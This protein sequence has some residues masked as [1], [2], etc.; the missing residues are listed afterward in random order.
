[1]RSPG[2]CRTSSRT[3]GSID[4]DP[5]V[6]KIRV[7]TARI[8]VRA[9]LVRRD[10]QSHRHQPAQLGCQPRCSP[11]PANQ[12][13]KK[14]SEG[15]GCRRPSF[16]RVGLVGTDQTGGLSR[17]AHGA[18][19]S[20]VHARVSAVIPLEPIEAEF[21]CDTLQAEKAIA[22]VQGGDMSQS[23]ILSSGRS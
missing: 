12:T 20:F 9:C 7:R 19:G 16:G 1:M 6:G 18:A 4:G 14:S 2:D 15:R 13:R 22:A 21:D 8:G 10:R 5:Q 23:R 11:I 17:S 3:T